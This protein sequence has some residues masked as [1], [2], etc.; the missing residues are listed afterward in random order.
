MFRH[1]QQLIDQLVSTARDRGV[2]RAQLAEQIGLTVGE[3]TRAGE[4][5]DIPA[6]TLAALGERLGF[7]LS[8]VPR[9]AG[10]QTREKAIQDIKTG[11]FF[12]RGA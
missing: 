7:E 1:I 11:V 8:F 12:R 3:L 6:A 9:Q 4:R 2:S 5:G 10:N